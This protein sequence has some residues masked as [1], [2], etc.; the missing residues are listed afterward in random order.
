MKIGTCS[1]YVIEKV[2]SFYRTK[3]V[4][5]CFERIEKKNNNFLF[6]LEDLKYKKQFAKSTKV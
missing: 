4:S 1:F 6:L 5:C 2:A 3:I